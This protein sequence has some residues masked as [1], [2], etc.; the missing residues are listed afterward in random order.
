MD[1]RSRTG[2]GLEDAWRTCCA[3]ELIISAACVV[4]QKGG[5]MITRRSA[6]ALAIWMLLT[7][8]LMAGPAISSAEGAGEAC[9]T[10]AC[11]AGSDSA[12]KIAC[13][14]ACTHWTSWGSR[15]QVPPVRAGAHAAAREPAEAAVVRE[16]GK[17][18]QQAEAEKELQELLRQARL[19]IAELTAAVNA[20]EARL[21]VG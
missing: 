10:E 12:G 15:M 20:Q 19:A 1:C 9:A 21:Q 4:A 2:F 6:A 11:E 16:Q 3:V 18:S 8:A 17:S 5:E 14:N 7:L 13:M